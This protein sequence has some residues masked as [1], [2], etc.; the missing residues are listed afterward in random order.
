[1]VLTLEKH[2]SWLARH[3]VSLVCKH[4]LRANLRQI[5][6]IGLIDQYVCVVT[7]TQAFRLSVLVVCR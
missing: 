1:M 6:H 4:Y 5:V 3:A 2:Q 7:H